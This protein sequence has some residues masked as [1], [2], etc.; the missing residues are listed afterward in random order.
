MEGILY[1]PGAGR[2]PP[3][4][5]GRTAQLAAW[6]I[7]LNNVAAEGRRASEDW[8]LLGPR[9]VGKTVLLTAMAERARDVGYQVLAFQAVVGG[10]GLVD[11][12]RAQAGELA[13]HGAYWSRLV[14]WLG[15]ATI[16]VGGVSAT[17]RPPEATSPG[18]DPTVMARQLA[19]V[20]EAIRGKH[21]SGGLLI[22]LD[23]IQVAAGADLALLAAVLQQASI[24]C[25][26]SP[27]IFAACGLPTTMTALAQAGVTHP[28][29]LFRTEVIPQ[30]LS[31][32]AATQ[33]L[34]GPALDREVVWEPAAVR[35]V[36]DF[37][38]GYPAHL[39]LVA[40]LTWELAPGPSTIHEADAIRGVRAAAERLETST[41]EPRW[42]QLTDREREYL[43]AVA[44]LGPTATTPVVSKLLGGTTASFAPVRDRLLK[45]GDLVS[46]GRGRIAV[47]SPVFGEYVLMRYPDAVAAAAVELTALDEMRRR[48]SGE[49]PQLSG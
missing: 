9:G 19:G 22:T 2:M 15:E 11:S 35:R 30:R 1:S 46:T 38:L 40:A 33:A 47:A 24:Q 49:P 26:T 27:L 6:D 44:L 48:R 37:T 45:A 7:M 16:G 4:L 12:L 8:L 23:E 36:L 29:R 25:R 42:D 43:A 5:T 13:A 20:A 28:D 41:L 17:I 39:Q 34:V 14:A 31:P 10:V 3:E 21:P 32:E 18:K